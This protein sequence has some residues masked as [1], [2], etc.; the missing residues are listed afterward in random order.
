[1][2]ES[3]NAYD[4][5]AGAH[6]TDSLKL[7]TERQKYYTAIQHAHSA[8]QNMLTGEMVETIQITW[9]LKPAEQTVN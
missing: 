8:T 6:L 3:V 9:R 2:D 7:L 4:A 1:M 5:F